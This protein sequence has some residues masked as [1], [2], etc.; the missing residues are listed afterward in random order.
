[1]TADELERGA[2]ART[3]RRQTLVSAAISIF[4]DVGGAGVSFLLAGWATGEWFRLAHMVLSVAVLVYLV[5]R[6]LATVR[7]SVIGWLLLTL[8][9]LPL[10]VLWTL[11]AP[12]SRMLE[13]F[14]AQKMVLIGVALLAPGP[15][16][17]GLAVTL[18]VVIESLFLSVMRLGGLRGG[19]PWVT[20]FY[21]LFAVGLLLH[22][23][24][25][26]RLSARLL[27]ANLETAALERMQLRSLEVR[28]RLNTPLQTLEVGVE[29]LRR[30]HTDEKTNS[31]VR[32]LSN[33]LE[34]LK[35]L[36]QQ[37]AADD[38]KGR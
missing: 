29:L 26:R 1:V 14:I 21:G 28:D 19:E 15:V 18:A 34:R 22:R 16:V 3:A 7:A 35:S 27:R 36:S 32:R 2:A 5:K 10:L 25:E 17:I 4:G 6:P 8:P 9:V 12:E 11:E 37:L 31:L 20:I 38:R 33:A 23:A 13:P 30:G 24:S